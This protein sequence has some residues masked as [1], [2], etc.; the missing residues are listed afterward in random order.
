MDYGG[1]TQVDEN[2]RR[3]QQ[4]DAVNQAKFYFRREIFTPT[5]SR[6]TSGAATPDIYSASPCSDPS[7]VNGI[8][9][10]LHGGSNG[11]PK[12]RMM[13]NCFPPL[14]LPDEGLV[15]G[16]VKEEYGEYTMDE[17]IN[18]RVSGSTLCCFPPHTQSPARTYVFF[19]FPP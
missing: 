16:S 3:A 12:Q 15:G 14:P 1:F 7:S 5:S 17:I 4:R 10:G 9:N 11:R 18:G 13:E 8:T 19:L 2:M 6:A